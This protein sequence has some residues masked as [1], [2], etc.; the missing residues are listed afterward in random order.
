MSYHLIFVALASILSIIN[1]QNIVTSYSY[2][3]INTYTYEYIQNYLNSDFLT[4]LKQI[5]DIKQD[6]LIIS[7]IKATS[8]S[9]RLAFSYGN[10]DIGLFLFSP[11]K[12]TVTYS[13]NYKIGEAEAQAATLELSVFEIKVTLGFKEDTKEPDVTVKIEKRDKDFDVYNAKSEDEKQVI[14][15]L[16]QGFESQGVFTDYAQ[17]IQTGI[18][19]LYSTMY[20]S[21]PSF[22]YQSSKLLENRKVIVKLDK[23]MGF[24][25]D[26]Q[27]TYESAVCFY[28][29]EVDQEVKTGIYEDALKKEEFKAPGDDYYS[30]I[31]YNLFNDAI[32]NMISQKDLILELS[33]TSFE[34]ISFGF[35]VKDLKEI[36]SDISS[37]FADTDEYVVKSKITS[38]SI[39]DTG[40]VTLNMEN[41][42]TIK[43]TPNVIVFTLQ[44][45]LQPNAKVPSYASFDLCISTFTIREIKVT[46]GRMEHEDILKNRITMVFDKAVQYPTCLSDNGIDLKDYYRYLDEA[47]IGE[48]GVYLKGKHLYF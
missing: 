26:V 13:F 1:G 32:T 11:K 38:M 23:F 33:K 22:E 48:K 34:E 41:A 17:T 42:I 20:K 19:N 25:K 10:M 24:C 44:M 40:I 45:E 35:T 16:I 43:D 4:A 3:K 30:F 18:T 47:E 14:D 29:G 27:K 2:D 15:A 28:S 31:H 5:D 12:L 39:A 36:F 6:N 8:S 46:T 7:D 21:K 37:D 9:S